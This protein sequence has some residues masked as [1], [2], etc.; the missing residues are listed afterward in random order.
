MGPDFRIDE[1]VDLAD[2]VL[3]RWCRSPRGDRSGIGAEL[4]Y[5]EIVT[6]REAHAILIEHFRDHAEALKAVG[7]EA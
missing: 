1:I 2:G 6:Y 4:R 7:L 5:S 3:V